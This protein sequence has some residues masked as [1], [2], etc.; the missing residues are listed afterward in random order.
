[1]DSNFGLLFKFWK[2]MDIIS[3]KYQVQKKIENITFHYNEINGKMYIE[4]KDENEVTIEF[5][6][7]TDFTYSKINNNL[8][9][10]MGFHKMKYIIKNETIK[11]DG[12]VDLYGPKYLLIIVENPLMIIIYH[13]I[14]KNK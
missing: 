3:Q 10:L 7:F 5:F 8:G 4:S 2:Q 12:V 1:M 14:G 6:N 9:Y 11:S 13:L